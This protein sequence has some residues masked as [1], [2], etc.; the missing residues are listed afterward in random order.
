MPLSMTRAI[1]G[2]LSADGRPQTHPAIAVV[3]VSIMLNG[4]HASWRIS[5]SRRLRDVSLLH[6][7]LHVAESQRPSPIGKG[8][9]ACDDVGSGGRI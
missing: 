4:H 1:T 2:A 6:I 9:L 7:W 5:A 3:D 8:P